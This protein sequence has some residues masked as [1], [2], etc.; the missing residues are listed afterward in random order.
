MSKKVKIKQIK[1]TIKRLESQKKNLNCF[2]FK[3]NWN[4]G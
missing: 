1:S 2:R 4:G 3:K